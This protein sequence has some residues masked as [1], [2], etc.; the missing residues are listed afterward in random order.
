MKLMLDWHMWPII[1]S[2]PDLPLR[3]I[4]KIN[5]SAMLGNV[6][7]LLG[8]QGIFKENKKRKKCA[9]HNDIAWHFLEP[10][11]LLKITFRVN[12]DGPQAHNIH[13]LWYG[14]FHKKRRVIK[15]LAEKQNVVVGLT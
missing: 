14:V 8:K 9:G 4:G 10:S 13:L 6:N 12:V 7:F 11:F 15:F 2:H 5:V 3:N 1:M